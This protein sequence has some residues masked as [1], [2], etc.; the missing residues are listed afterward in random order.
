[1]AAGLND[2]CP[3]PRPLLPLEQRLEG[4]GEEGEARMPPGDKGYTRPGFPPWVCSREVHVADLP[5][6]LGF[7]VLTQ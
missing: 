7:R 6:P 3:V 1:M 2:S 5:R 4:T